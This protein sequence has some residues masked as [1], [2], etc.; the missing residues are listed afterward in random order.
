MVKIVDNDD[1]LLLE[2]PSQAELEE[3]VKTISRSLSNEEEHALQIR[4][5]KVFNL[6]TLKN[7]WNSQVFEE[8]V[9]KIKQTKLLKFIISK[10]DKFS[11]FL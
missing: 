7:E 10:P 5:S 4:E 8:L 11:H 3:I 9:E 2:R 1:H 6:D